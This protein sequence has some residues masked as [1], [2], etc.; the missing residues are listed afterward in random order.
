MDT[1]SNITP[2]AS[3]TPVSP[4]EQMRAKIRDAEKEFTQALRAEFQAMYDRVDELD[5]G[6]SE[7][8]VVHSDG[9]ICGRRWTRCSRASTRSSRL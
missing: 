9:D 2:T 6:I 4:L 5:D 1:I 8:G 3:T 7:V